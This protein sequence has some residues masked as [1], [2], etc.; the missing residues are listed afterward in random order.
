MPVADA[1]LLESVLWGIWLSTSASVVTGLPAAIGACADLTE[2]AGGVE[3]A[4]VSGSGLAGCEADS[5]AS[6]LSPSGRS[7]TWFCVAA[8]T[9]FCGKGRDA[10]ALDWLLGREGAADSASAAASEAS[11]SNAKG[12]GRVGRAAFVSAGSFAGGAA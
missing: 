8:T 4:A 2:E 10:G 12:A 5:L 9:G 3:L 7:L 11:A 1:R 6:E